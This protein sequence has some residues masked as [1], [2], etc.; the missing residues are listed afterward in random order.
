[1]G[2]RYGWW[3]KYKSFGGERPQMVWVGPM[4]EGEMLE[5]F[6]TFRHNFDGCQP[7]R[8]DTGVVESISICDYCDRE[9]DIDVCGR[10]NEY[11]YFTGRKM[12]MIANKES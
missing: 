10:C 9:G 8:P 2:H 4:Y 5:A 12:R 6:E 3:G 7:S 1:M 11:E